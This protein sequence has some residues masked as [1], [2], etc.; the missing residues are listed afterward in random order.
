M[1]P[2]ARRL[3]PWLQPLQRALALA[4]PEGYLRV[5]VDD[6]LALERMPTLPSGTEIDGVEVVIRVRPQAS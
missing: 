6:E 4:E 1:A 5:F 3:P 2:T